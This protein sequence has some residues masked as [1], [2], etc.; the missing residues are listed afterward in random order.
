MTFIEL[1][2]SLFM[3]TLLHVCLDVTLV[4]ASLFGVV[5]ILSSNQQSI[6]LDDP[7]IAFLYLLQV[8]VSDTQSL[9]G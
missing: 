3:Q 2:S 5:R 4:G 6:S 9:Y 8:A 7:L 1:I